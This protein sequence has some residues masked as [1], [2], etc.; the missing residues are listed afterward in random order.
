MEE[1]DNERVR[2]QEA[3]DGHASSIDE[4][5]DRKGSW[6]FQ[7]LV[8]DVDGALV[9]LPTIECQDA[10]IHWEGVV[11]NVNVHG[12]GMMER[13]KVTVN[14]P[15]FVKRIVEIERGVGLDGKVTKVSLVRGAT[16]QGAVYAPG[17]LPLS[18]VVIEQRVSQGGL[19]GVPQRQVLAE[20]GKD[21]SFEI[22]SVELKVLHLWFSHEM[23]PDLLLRVDASLGDVLGLRV[24][25]L[26]GGSISGVVM[27]LGDLDCS[28]VRVTA[29]FDGPLGMPRPADA[30]QSV[31]CSDTGAFTLTGLAPN[32]QG[33]PYSLRAWW[34]SGPGRMQIGGPVAARTGATE[35]EMSVGVVPLM[36]EVQDAETGE[37]IASDTIRV[38][39]AD[40]AKRTRYPVLSVDKGDKTAL[41]V[42]GVQGSL[43]IMAEVEK[44][45]YYGKRIKISW[46]LDGV[47]LVGGVVSLD[48]MKVLDIMVTNG[49]D[50]TPVSGAEICALNGRVDT[51]EITRQM[52]SIQAASEV[53]SY[54]KG[55]RQRV[56]SDDRG[57]AVIYLPSDEACHLAANHPEVGWFGPLSIEHRV[58][59]PLKIELEMGGQVEVEGLDQWTEAVPE[60]RIERVYAV[61]EPL[62]KVMGPNPIMEELVT[63]ADGLASFINLPAGKHYFRA[64]TPGAG[65]AAQ[66]W[67]ST[68]LGVAERKKVQVGVLDTVIGYG[69][70][71]INGTPLPD[72]MVT[73]VEEARYQSEPSLDG[74][75]WRHL[76]GLEREGRIARTDSRGSFQFANGLPTGQFRLK[77]YSQALTHPFEMGIGLR[78]GETPIEVRIVSHPLAGRVEDSMG[79]PV[80]GAWVKLLKGHNLAAATDSLLN[81]A[82]GAGWADWEIMVRSD[83]SGLFV[84]P[85]LLPRVDYTVMA[86]APGLSVGF[87]TLNEYCGDPVTTPLV[88][89]LRKAGELQMSLD[90]GLEVQR[91]RLNGIRATPIGDRI[92]E[93]VLER[94]ARTSKWVSRENG[95]SLEHLAPGKWRIELL[96]RGIAPEPFT[97]EVLPGETQAVIIKAR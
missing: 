47:S 77:V 97:V 82:S 73:M 19:G 62:S 12:E 90:S 52:A 48:P 34:G 13:V 94:R 33:A 71:T 78:G 60:T 75:S 96:S 26:K 54:L 3:D 69:T 27:G 5:Q 39:E 86:T 9:A 88:L 81:A 59:E 1:F 22:D 41:A 30:Q 15:G 55:A 42:I 31:K 70:V 44:S 32:D 66:I 63:D 25:L 28:Q 43:Q 80:G 21:G 4:P 79:N 68:T 10:M 14:A 57:R 45:G 51:D 67:T 83:K 87:R 40:G 93:C 92:G 8:V 74:L 6:G 38:Y 16:L 20:T 29:L 50:G 72:A 17:G 53:G 7:V 46:S 35:L 85:N 91:D 58:D 49:L 89:S 2:V 84:F 56:F 11:A 61:E 18:G 23:Y 36:L 95:L 24:Q 37:E 64:V 65:Q 76:S